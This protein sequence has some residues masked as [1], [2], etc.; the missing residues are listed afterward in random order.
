MSTRPSFF[1]DRLRLGVRASG[2][3]WRLLGAGAFLTGIGF[4]MSLFIAGLA[5]TPAMLAAAK[6]GI[7]AASVT[8]AAGLLILVW[9]TSG[10][11]PRRASR[12]AAR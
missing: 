3:S 12:G 4:T 11:M 1:A 6:L 7:L 10:E 2:L 5:L 8:S 9:L